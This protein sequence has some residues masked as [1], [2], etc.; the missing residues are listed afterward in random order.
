MVGQNCELIEFFPCWWE[1]I[2][3]EAAGIGIANSTNLT[4]SRAPFRHHSAFAG[5]FCGVVEMTC[6]VAY[7]RFESHGLGDEF[8]GP[9]ADIRDGTSRRMAK[10]SGPSIKDGPLQVTGAGGHCGA[11]RDA[12]YN[13]A[14]D[15]RG[16]YAPTCA[17]FGG[18]IWIAYF[19]LLNELVAWHSQHGPRQSLTHRKERVLALEF[20]PGI[21]Q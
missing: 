13:S 12:V 14:C 18:G 11:C 16:E 8:L 19:F 6:I 7:A 5:T 10:K 9:G 20:S 3:A 1:C 2:K 17:G 15:L 4:L 21:F